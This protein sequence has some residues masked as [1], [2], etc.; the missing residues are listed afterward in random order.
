MHECDALVVC[1]TNPS[2][3][4]MESGKPYVIQ[5]AGGD[6]MVA[7]GLYRAGPVTDKDWSHGTI[8]E[9]LLR[10]AF[11]QAIGIGVHDTGIE[12]DR[13]EGAMADMTPWRRS[14]P[15]IPRKFLATYAHGCDPLSPREQAIL[16]TELNQEF[17]LAMDPDK[18][19]VLV[20]SRVDFLWKGH[21]KL[22]Q[23]F[24]DP[25]IS[26]KYQFIFTAW[27]QITK[28]CARLSKRTAGPQTS[29][30]S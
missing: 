28:I 21:D 8:Y 17:N 12:M 1:G 18:P 26:E 7:M 10:K 22:A 27:G 29:S 9:Q 2:I 6:Y 25:E 4:A 3:L 16:R 20:P 19:L 15:R 23:A 14:A 30:I 24:A 5:P 11:T 13:I